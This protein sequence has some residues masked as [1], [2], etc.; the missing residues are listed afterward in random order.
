MIEKIDH[1]GIAVNSI[2]ERLRFFKDMLS[3]ELAGTEEINDQKVKVAFVKVGDVNIELLEPTD[4]ASPIAKFIAK[5]GEGIH[6]IALKTNNISETLKHLTK[7]NITLIDTTP[8]QG[9]HGKKIAFIHP[10]ST[11]GVLIEL[12]QE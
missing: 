5:K 9:A 2:E 6:H 12:C 11:G 4:P 1:I 10:K 8:R 3:L 7:N